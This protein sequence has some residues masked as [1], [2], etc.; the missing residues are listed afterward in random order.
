[1]QRIDDGT[2]IIYLPGNHDEALRPFLPMRLGNITFRDEI[3]HETADGRRYLVVHGD[4]FDDV[5]ERM[6]LLAYIGDVLY[7]WLLRWNG[8]VNRVRARLK[9][10][11]WSLSAWAKRR[12]KSACTFVSNFESTLA[13][14]AKAKACQGVICGHI[15][16][17]EDRQIDGIH[18]LNTGD[19]V[20]SLT[21]LV[22]HH[23]G[24]MEVLRCPGGVCHVAHLNISFENPVRIAA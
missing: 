6:R 19:W 2:E 16:T 17:A 22:E 18:Y 4:R 5:M 7:T 10:E 15:H 13:R 12:V 21:A 20:E 3:V 9:M 24:R 11:P 23:D 14:A 8:A 1:M